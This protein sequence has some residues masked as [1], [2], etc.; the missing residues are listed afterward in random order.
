[1][2]AENTNVA[3]FISPVIV[4]VIVFAGIALPFLAKSTSTTLAVFAFLAFG[5][6]LSTSRGLVQFIRT[7]KFNGDL[8]QALIRRRNALAVNAQRAGEGA[9]RKQLLDRIPG[10]NALIEM[11]QTEPVRVELLGVPMN[12]NLLVRLMTLLAGA[13]LSLLFSEFRGSL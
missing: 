7:S 6:G 2:D 9:R 1:M 3:S 11:Q 5:C 10:L 4:F 8:V 13:T 12:E